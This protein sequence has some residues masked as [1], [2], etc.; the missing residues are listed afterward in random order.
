[1]LGIYIE[2]KGLTNAKEFDIEDFNKWQERQ[3][4]IDIRTPEQ[5]NKEQNEVVSNKN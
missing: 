2:E 4:V 3:R 5:K 1:M